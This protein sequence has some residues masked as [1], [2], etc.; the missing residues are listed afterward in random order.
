M[1]KKL[2]AG[3]ATGLLVFGMASM[4]QAA[5]TTIGTATYGGSDYKLI[6]DDDD[7][8]YG[9]GGLVWLDYTKS[10]A[11]WLDARYAFV[12]VLGP[13]L[14]INLNPGVTTNIDWT[15]GWRL[16]DTGVNIL[17]KSTYG[18]VGD[19]N[20]DGVYTYTSGYN[21]A[22]SEI[23][24][25]FYTELGNLGYLDT[26]G[27]ARSS[28]DYGLSNTG[29]F[30]NLTEDYY[31]SAMERYY[32]AINNAWAFNTEFGAQAVWP[33]LGTESAIAVISGNVNVSAVPVPG[34]IWLLGSGLAALMGKGLR[35]KKKA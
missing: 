13:Q 22:N 16:P 25:L 5:L 35:R 15:T 4:A 2:L 31:W 8:G 30:E 14:S 11:T 20:S 10:S 29:E 28:G 27:A 9:S 21:L 24:H 33:F 34:A 1:K 32:W 26:S 23:G 3:L 7:T 6:Y 19:P 17:L 18:Y 12:D